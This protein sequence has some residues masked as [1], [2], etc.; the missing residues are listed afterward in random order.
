MAQIRRKQIE[1]EHRTVR[2][3]LLRAEFE[4]QKA[5]MAL[6]V[7]ETRA[8]LAEELQLKNEELESFSYSVAHDLRAP[9]RS[10]DGFSLALLEDCGDRLDDD[11]R[12]YLHYVRE[13][14][15]HMARLIDDLLALSRVTRGELNRGETHLRVRWPGASSLAFN[16]QI[17][18]AGS[19]L[20]W[21][22]ELSPTA[23]IDY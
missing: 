21:R 1:D 19:M 3:Q 20:L 14:A 18:I 23:T 13:L 2:E 8:A 5:R 10:I 11:G 16:G 17:L 12:R 9:L 15:Q 4:A 6:E 7:A 22:M